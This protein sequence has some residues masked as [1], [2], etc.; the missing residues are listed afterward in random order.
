MLHCGN[1]LPQ[2]R[3]NRLADKKASRSDAEPND[4]RTHREREEQIPRRESACRD[5]SARREKVRQHERHH[6]V[7]WVY[8]VMPEEEQRGAGP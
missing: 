2:P 5:R 1:I 6:V 4:E 3:C 7:P 8:Q